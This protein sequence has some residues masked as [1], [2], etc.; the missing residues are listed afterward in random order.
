VRSAGSREIARS[1]IVIGGFVTLVQTKI[2]VE[3]NGRFDAKT[4]AA[5]RVFQRNNDLVGDGIVG[6]RTWAT[7]MSDGVVTWRAGEGGETA[8]DAASPGW[9]RVYLIVQ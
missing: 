8:R 7:L 6:P 5:V 1:T 3:S 4:E 9:R 2:R